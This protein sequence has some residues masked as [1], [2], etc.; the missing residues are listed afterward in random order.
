MKPKGVLMGDSVNYSAPMCPVCEKSPAILSD[1]RW[2]PY[3]GD[4]CSDVCG[5][6]AG[7]AVQTVRAT[8]E[9]KRLNRRIQDDTLALAIMQRTAVCESGKQL[10]KEQCKQFWQPYLALWHSRSH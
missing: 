6:C 5:A 9:Y 2:M 10:K 8:A 7:S 1:T 4:A 3:E